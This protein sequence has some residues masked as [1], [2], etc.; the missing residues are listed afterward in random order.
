MKIRKNKINRSL[1]TLFLI[2]LACF[3]LVP[4]NAVAAKS[5]TLVLEENV[6]VEDFEKTFR[7]GRDLI[8]KEEWA[9]AAE[10]FNEV[11][12]KYPDNK[13]SDAAL[14]WL[15]FCYKKQKM[16]KETDA[17]LDRLIRDFPT[18]SWADDARVMKLEIAAPLGRWVVGGRS[19]TTAALVP[20]VSVATPDIVKAVTTVRS[21]TGA[22]NVTPVAVGGFEP[23]GELTTVGAQTPL[24]REDEI[25]IAAFQSL[26]S[27]DSKKGLEALGEI[28]KADSKASET[29]K[30]EVLR[31]LRRPHFGAL[32]S[33]YSNG[34][35]TTTPMS[36]GLNSAKNETFAPQLREALLKSFQNQPN[37]KIRKEIIYTLA[38]SKDDQSV[39][40]LARLYDS[41]NDG[42][43][44]KAIINGFGAV[45]G[46]SD[47]YL[48]RVLSGSGQNSAITVPDAKKQTQRAEF[49][50]L[51][52][53]AR[54]EK[55]AELRALAL[56]NL[57]RFDGWGTNAEIFEI[58]SRAY[59]SETNEDLKKTIIRS[60]GRSKHSAASKKLLD[61]A[62]ND[63]SDKLRIE[64]IY[65]LRNVNTPEAL[66]Y[67]E[68]LVK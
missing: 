57:Q 25:K 10:K 20:G 7:E 22:T 39:D 61:I 24:D 5:K 17:A 48:A 18:S 46:R 59:D 14:Y 67:L 2:A 45:G 62:K 36:S 33:E 65:A 41:E 52:E 28:L 34:L 35:L 30:I 1:P 58:L 3:V 26:L 43:V 53:I 51:L 38:A 64:A 19:G 31:V 29:F 32:Y 54:S 63:K 37:I 49:S 12:G 9:K 11:L 60:F 50:K 16:F 55:N 44:K 23:F 66:E 68:E 13:A 40:Y 8:D 56:S 4:E 21:T 47:I 42:E 27:A 6:V 15:A